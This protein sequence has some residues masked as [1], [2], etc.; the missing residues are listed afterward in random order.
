[1]R[2][3]RHPAAEYLIT[4]D[5]TAVGARVCPR[6]AQ[7]DAVSRQR[8]DRG[9]TDTVQRNTE[10]AGASERVAGATTDIQ[11]LVHQVSHMTPPLGGR[12]C[13]LRVA[14][15]HDIKEIVQERGF[16]APVFIQTAP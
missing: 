8:A 15:L 7:R 3:N 13:P 16:E 1:L 2:L 12:Y 5:A 10:S 9:G 11:Y 14:A 6:I 4:L